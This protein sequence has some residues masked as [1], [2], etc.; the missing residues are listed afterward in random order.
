MGNE[1]LILIETF[2]KEI[3]NT[4]VMF[5]KSGPLFPLI[6]R[7]LGTLSFRLDRYFEFSPRQVLCIFALT[8]TLSFRLDRY[9]EFSPLGT[10]SFRLDRYFEFSP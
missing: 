9:F 1:Y 10:L 6:G 5:H 4:Y 2:T 8:G 3:G 7:Y